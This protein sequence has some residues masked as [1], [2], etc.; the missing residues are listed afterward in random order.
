MSQLRPTKHSSQA[1]QRSARGLG[2]LLLATALLAIAG[3]QLFRFARDRM[4]SEELA[5]YYD[6]SEQKLFAAPR[7]LIPPIRGLNDETEDAFRAL[8]IS[9]T[10]KPDDEASRKIVYLEK[11]SPELKQQ[12]EAVQKAEE[13]DPTAPLPAK[14]QV[15]RVAS[16]A[17]RFVRRL[18]DSQWYPLNSPEA[19]KILAEWQTAGAAGREPVVCVP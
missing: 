17:H 2:K 13:E 12:I 5:Y 9:T 11:F 10:G 15:D 4:P 1:K 3:F 8:V 18:T 19:E 16:R 6:V 7:S 14:G